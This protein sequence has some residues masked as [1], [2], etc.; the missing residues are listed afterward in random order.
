MSI[1]IKN[2]I[3][4]GKIQNIYIEDNR[5]TQIGYENSADK[6][7]DG[8]NKIALPPFFNAHTHAAM[9]LFR[10]YGDDIPLQKWLE[11]KIWPNEA[12]LT[13]EDVYIGS[14]LACLEMIKTGTT[15]FNDMYWHLLGTKKAVDE[16]GIRA[17]LNLVFIDMFDQEKAKEQIE[18]NEELIGKSE[19]FSPRIRLS[20]GPH[21]I[22]TVSLKS[23]QWAKDIAD[24]YGYRI[25]IHVSET[26][27]EVNDCIAKH[28][29]RPIEYLNDIGILGKNMIACHAVWLNDKEIELL[30]AN[31]ATV[32]HNPVSNMKLSVGKA[33]PYQKLKQAG[34]NICLGTDGAASNNNLDMFES[35]KFAALL[36]KFATNEP[37][38]MPAQEVFDMATINGAKAFGIDIGIQEGRL[39][40]LILVDIKNPHMIPGHDAIS[41]IVYSANGSCVDTTICDGK[42]L[43]QNR[44]VTWEDDILRKAGKKAVE[45]FTPR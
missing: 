13:R 19:R 33:F 35:M 39:A 16:S 21:A 4:N 8:T 37:T 2:C 17:E 11:E 27:K 7:I 26:E 31:N 43:M 10:G 25:H 45:F 6:I 34:V 24:K 3:L 23:L 36:Q 28:G 22:Y 41:N 44:K 42:I 29:K 5:I 15:F 1:L 32:V 38:I 30:G 18:L 40:D 14:K 12:R 9:T 20:I